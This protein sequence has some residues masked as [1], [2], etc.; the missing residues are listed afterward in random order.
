MLHIRTWH[1]CAQIS[2]VAL[3]AL[4]PVAS[5]SGC[6]NDPDGYGA[7]RALG[8]GTLV[9][10]IGPSESHPNWP[11]IGGGA[12]LAARTL[13]NVDCFAALPQAGETAS[14]DAFLDRILARNPAAAIIC[15]D[16]PTVTGDIVRRLAQAG[17][18]TVTIGARTDD[19]SVFGHVAV[20]WPPAAELLGEQLPK[21]AGDPPN[22]NLPTVGPSYILI[23]RR[24]AG[25]VDAE[26][27]VRFAAAVSRMTL[28]RAV[29]VATAGRPAQQV[30]ADL[31]STFP[32][33][34][35]I[36][37][38][39][40]QPWLDLRPRF[41]LPEANR[42]AT[43]GAAPRLWPRLESGEAAALV[44]P[45]DGD[46][47]QTAFNLAVSGL[48]RIPEAR[49]YPMIPCELITPQTLPDFARRYAEAAGLPL[50]QLRPFGA[51]SV[52]TSNGAGD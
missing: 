27:Y 36:V 21:L 35:L 48:M 5:F 15:N 8:K 34:R 33:T 16:S 26:C 32:S 25:G 50:E 20:A 14:S 1:R 12:F 45:L 47:G 11:A 31:L 3:A 7:Q 13:P 37:T 43:L 4:L 28:L 9:A 49:R 42:F 46:I 18:L 41:K 19:P 44:G 30:V 23:H 40:P 38:L 24:S 51:E 22:P 10:V 6:K 52:P 2:L 29:D 39:D 17:L